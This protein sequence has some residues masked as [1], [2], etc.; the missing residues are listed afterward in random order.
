MKHIKNRN[1]KS[2]LRLTR[3]RTAQKRVR[4]RSSTLER[5]VKGQKAE[6]TRRT[7]KARPARQETLN[8]KNLQKQKR[9]TI[10]M[11]F[12]IHLIIF[13]L[14]LSDQKLSINSFSA[15]Q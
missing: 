4:S 15:I 13:I 9:L 8:H 2:C 1:R 12:F 10:F 5:R 6:R 3:L 14:N 7:R 11:T